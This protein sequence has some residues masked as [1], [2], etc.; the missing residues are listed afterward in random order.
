MY[1]NWHWCQWGSLGRDIQVWTSFSSKR[2]KRKSV[3]LLKY[4]IF[5]CEMKC[6][7]FVE[8]VKGWRCGFLLPFQT[9]FL[10][11]F[12]YLSL[13]FHFFPLTSQE[14]KQANERLLVVRSNPAWGDT[15]RKTWVLELPTRDRSSESARWVADGCR[16]CDGA[17][18]H[19]PPSEG[20][21]AALLIPPSVCV[22]ALPS[23]WQ[24]PQA[25]KMLL[26]CVRTVQSKNQMFPPILSHCV[27]WHG[28]TTS[29]R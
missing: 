27:C 15:W 10:Q 7:V 19:V 18:L 11:V 12:P 29:P 14:G 21:S 6:A 28:Y 13:V 5:L 26:P 3:F 25:T 17:M 2:C 22:G 1:V 23:P 8:K 9:L 16:C 4:L 24:L 20:M